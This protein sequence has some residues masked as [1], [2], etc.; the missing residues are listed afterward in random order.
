[1]MGTSKISFFILILAVGFTPVFAETIQY[2]ETSSGASVTLPCTALTNALNSCNIISGSILYNDASLLL[3]I[4][5]DKTSD[6]TL[7][8]TLPRVALD[9]ISNG[10]NSEFFVFVDG[11]HVIH[12]ESSNP[13]SRSLVIDIPPG[14][15]E[16][17]II[18]TK[19]IPEFPLVALMIV[20]TLSLVVI[21]S[22]FSNTNVFKIGQNLP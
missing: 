11:E 6:G 15:T 5:S 14:A 22:R 13:T 17:E 20:I 4:E 18:G 16:V 2:S 8:I 10:A 7:D 19:A 12:S 21:V 3:N 1:M 9:S